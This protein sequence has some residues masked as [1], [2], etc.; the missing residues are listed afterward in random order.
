MRAGLQE[1]E[2]LVR[3]TKICFRFLRAVPEIIGSHASFKVGKKTFACFLNDHH[4]DGIVGVLCKV[5]A[6][7]NAALI[8]ADPKRFYMPACVNREGG[9]DS[10]WMLAE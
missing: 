6:G 7:D 8:K 1:D 2:R 3:C 5:L 10:G 9:W 4:G